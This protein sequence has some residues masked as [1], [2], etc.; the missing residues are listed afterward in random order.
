MCAC[1]N[2][3]VRNYALSLY[4]THRHT[5]AH[6]CTQS[7]SINKSGTVLGIEDAVVNK[8][9][10]FF[11]P[12]SLHSGEQRQTINL[13]T[14]NKGVSEAIIGTKQVKPGKEMHRGK[15][16]GSGSIS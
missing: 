4:N 9:D 15:R 13:Y 10:K 11:P 16:K 8:P 14:D 12:R 7:Y 1:F 3:Y 6:T 2:L 5:R